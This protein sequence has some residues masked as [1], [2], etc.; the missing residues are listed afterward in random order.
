M[1]C[2]GKTCK[3][4]GGLRPPLDRVWTSGPLPEAV[5]N[6]T[7]ILHPKK[8]KRKGNWLEIISSYLHVVRCTWWYCVCEMRITCM[9][10]EVYADCAC[11]MGA[12]LL[13][14]LHAW[15]GVMW[16][17]TCCEMYPWAEALLIA[18]STRGCGASV[19]LWDIYDWLRHLHV[20]RC[21]W[22]YG[23]RD[24][25]VMFLYLFHHFMYFK[26]PACCEMCM[27]IVHVL[28]DWFRHLH[29]VRSAWW[30]CVRDA[31]VMFLYLFHHFMYFKLPACCEMCM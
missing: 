18:T 10:W 31:H 1:R 9:L 5:L 23:V 17:Y 25:H 2:P 28:H 15:K 27:L 4:G 20:V 14:L 16:V 29:A 7:H 30:Y 12:K 6:Q 22:W 3:K 19:W 24:A 13:L 26:L 21:A 8:T 11:E